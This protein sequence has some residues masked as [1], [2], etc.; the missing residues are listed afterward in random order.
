[1]TTPTRRRTWTIV[2]LLLAGWLAAGGWAL[3]EA[4]RQQRETREVLRREALALARTLGPALTAAAAAAEE[5]GEVLSWKLLDDTRALA[6]LDGAGALDGNTL[7]TFVEE[8]GLAAAVIL[9]PDGRVRLAAGEDVPAPVLAEAQD[10]LRG[11]VE[12]KLL[13]WSREEGQAHLAAIARSPRGAVLARLHPTRAFAFSRRLGVENLLDSLVRT[14]GI[15]YLAFSVQPA[16]Q[17]VE[18]SRDGQPV[19]APAG[20]D[21]GLLRVVRGRSVFEVLVPVEAPAGRN[22]VLQVG[23]DATALEQATA[24]AM[25]RTLLVAIVLSALGLLGAAFAVVL[26][27][28]AE[29]RAEAARRLA[30]AERA[31][32]ESE[33][34]AAAG[35]L[36]AGL[37]H[38]VRSPMN[39]IAMAAQ[40]IERH[41]G[42]GDTPR[43]LAATIRR[44]IRRLE[45]TLGGF[46]ALARPTSGPFEPV[47]PCALAREVTGLLVH[48]AEARGVRLELGERC[49]APV[50]ADREAL[51]R[52]LVNLVRNAIQASPEGGTV[53]VHVEVDDDVARLVVEDEGPGIPPEIKDRVFDAFVTTRAEGTGLGLSLVRR[54][55]EDHGGRVVL[56]DRAGGG[57]R[58]EIVLPRV[59]DPGT[60][61]GGTR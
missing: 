23:L 10:V 22:A 24:A 3:R 21:R 47:D 54:T 61:G 25:R 57:T 45:E 42:A 56:T 13:D 30:D 8:A 35:A 40:R 27:Q 60:E 9:A 41:P 1:M 34:L 38:E 37:A 44:E 29:E 58:A 15:V 55:V 28:R 11:R 16:G 20:D 5:L 17:R 51:R 39:A 43:D 4:R 33:R 32:Q 2:V 26:R 52:A 18:A 59:Q 36:A 7:E 53:W 48:E 19:P 31:R 50:R 6:L 46:L 14:P 49:G 12:E